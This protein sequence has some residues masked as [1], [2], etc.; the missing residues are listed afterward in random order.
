[1][2]KKMLIVAKLTKIVEKVLEE[3]GNLRDWD[4]LEDNA[5]EI[6]KAIAKQLS[7]RELGR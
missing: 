3:Q 1:M 4:D 6:S 2:A 7:V 5:A